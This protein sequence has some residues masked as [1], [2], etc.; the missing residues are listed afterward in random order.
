M[1]SQ[2]RTNS[3]IVL[4]ERLEDFVKEYFTSLDQLTAHYE[5]FKKRKVFTL[6]FSTTSTTTNKTKADHL[7]GPRDASVYTSLRMIPVFGV[8]RRVLD[9]LIRYL[10][11]RVQIDRP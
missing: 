6:L 1:P 2:V 8:V 7:Y 3:S 5:R 11:M 9:D 10:L 4:R